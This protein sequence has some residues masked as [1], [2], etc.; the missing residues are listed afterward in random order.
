MP[1]AVNENTL[2]INLTTSL[3]LYHVWSLY[4]QD[5]SV[6]TTTLSAALN[7]A[8]SK[9]KD[10]MAGPCVTFPS[11]SNS[12]PWQEQLY[13]LLAWSAMVQPLCVQM[14]EYA[15]KEVV[16]IRTSVKLPSA[17]ESNTL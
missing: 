6:I 16:E 8:V 14:C 4:Y 9:S 12:D 10:L 5:H 11:K 2:L 17:F 13:I 15:L 1:T 3:K 7:V